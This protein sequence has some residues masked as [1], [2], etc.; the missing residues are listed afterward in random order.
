MR[1]IWIVI[2]YSSYFWSS[3][4]KSEESSPMT[5]VD[6]KLLFCCSLD[7]FNERSWWNLT[8][9]CEVGSMRFSIQ[10]SLSISSQHIRIYMIDGQ[11]QS[12]LTWLITLCHNCHQYTGHHHHHCCCSTGSWA[13][14]KTYAFF[15][16]LL[17]VVV[18]FFSVSKDC[19][20]C[21]CLSL[22]FLKRVGIW[23]SSNYT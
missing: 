21:H 13:G 4:W 6:V 11:T 12:Y 22:V 16:E 5:H 18:T 8:C 20:F 15:E 10:E 9:F 17:M 2:W 23:F 14:A 3:D 19:F 7:E 1:C